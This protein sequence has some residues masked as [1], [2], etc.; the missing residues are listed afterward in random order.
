[1][2]VS[3]EAVQAATAKVTGVDVAKLKGPGRHRKVTLPRHIAMYVAR[4]D[5]ASYPA[6]ARGFG[7]RDHTTVLAAVRVVARRLLTDGWIVATVR[8]VREACGIAA[9]ALAMPPRQK[10]RFFVRLAAHASATEAMDAAKDAVSLPRLHAIPSCP[11]LVVGSFEI[12][13]PGGAP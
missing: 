1:M 7:G 9:P 3:I 2:T 13:P 4:L 5:G 10:A 6:I 11:G 12:D 8:A